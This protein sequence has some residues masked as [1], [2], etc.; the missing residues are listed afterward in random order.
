MNHAAPGLLQ[1]DTVLKNNFYFSFSS[2][3]KFRHLSEY[4]SQMLRKALD[5]FARLDV[6]T[7][8]QVMHDDEEADSEYQS[9]MR[10]LITYMMEDPRKISEVLDVIWV[11][12]ALERIGDHAKNIGEY[13]IYLVKGKDVRHLDIEEVEKKILS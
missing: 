5:S 3:L 8:I 4:V 2:L 6:E 9:L 11:A 13:V 7:A 10:Q 1:G 12:R